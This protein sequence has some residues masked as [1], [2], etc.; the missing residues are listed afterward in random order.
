MNYKITQK[1][2]ELKDYEVKM[3]KMDVKLDSLL[4]RLSEEY[5]ITYEKALRRI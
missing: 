5:Q 1:Q 4:N 3:G 2:N